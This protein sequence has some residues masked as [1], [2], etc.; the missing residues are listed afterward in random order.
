MAASDLELTCGIRGVLT[1]HAIDLTKTNFFARR[2]H[3][4]MSGEVAL[5][6]AN[7]PPEQTADTLKACESE[8]RRLQEVRT[9]SFEFT[10]WIRDDLGGWICLEDDSASS[11]GQTTMGEES[12]PIAD[13]SAGAG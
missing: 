6:G 5:V 1:R 3:V 7:R 9:L 4:H 10:N 13:L 8:L 11:E 12:H 2:G